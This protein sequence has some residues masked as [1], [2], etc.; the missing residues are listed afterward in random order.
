MIKRILYIAI[1]P[2]ILAL[3]GCSNLS[4]NETEKKISIQDKSFSLEI[5]RTVE[6]HRKGLMNRSSLDADKGMLFLFENKEYPQFWMKDT[7]IPLQVL[8]IEGCRIVDLI[9]MEK[10]KDP[11]NA[12]MIYKS[13]K[14]ADKAI[15]LN[16]KTFDRTIIGQEI[17]EL[18]K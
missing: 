7:L 1:L 5:A 14:L 8:M 9:E 6:E 12:Q 13:S 17:K 18:C 15:E 16:S 4:K 11:S 3:A 2:A 10:E